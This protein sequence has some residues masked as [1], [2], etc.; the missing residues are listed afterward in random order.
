[1][2]AS[3]PFTIE[4]FAAGCRRLHGCGL[5]AA[6]VIAA[7]GKL[8]PLTAAEESLIAERLDRPDDWV[9]GWVHRLLASAE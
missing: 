8:P 4:A 1:M 7:L 9:R 6:D 3:L 5:T 2:A